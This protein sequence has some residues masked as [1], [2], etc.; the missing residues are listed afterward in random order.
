MNTAKFS[1]DSTFAIAVLVTGLVFGI[2]PATASVNAERPE[3]A[4]QA[5]MTL[6]SAGTMKLT[7]T[8]AHERS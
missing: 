4:Q 7:V 6:T 2:L 8:A 5:Q 3:A 1:L